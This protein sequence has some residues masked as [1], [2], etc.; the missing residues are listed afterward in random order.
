MVELRERW[1]ELG[2]RVL[3]VFGSVVLTLCLTECG[4]RVFGAAPLP[5]TAAGGFRADHPLLRLLERDKCHPF[6]RPEGAYWVEVCTNG[7]GLRDRNH[8]PGESP[9]VLGLGDSFTFGWGVEQGDTFLAHLERALRLALPGKRPGVWNAGLSYTSQVHQ[10]ALL[11]YVHQEAR[12]DLVVLAFAEDNDIDE[13]IIWNPNNGVFPEQGEISQ[14]QVDAYREELQGVIVK[15]FLFRHM[16]LVRFFRQR[17]VRASV[18]AEVSALETQLKAHGLSDAP[19]S[20]MIADEARR[21]FLQAFSFKYDDDW[22]VTEILLERIRRFLAERGTSLVL[23]R[24]PS[25]M[26]VDDRAWTNAVS[27]FCGKDVGDVQTNCGTLDRSHTAQRL[28]EYA[29]RQGVAYLDPSQDLH[30][31]V[32]RGENIYLPEDIHLSRLGHLRLGERLARD[33]LPALGAAPPS[34]P[35]PPAPNTRGTRL[36]GAYF[37]PWYRAGDWRSFT[38]YSPKGGDYIST[39]KATIHKQLQ[40]AERGEIDF[41]IIE[42]VA[43]HNRESKFNN[44]AIDTLVRTIAERRRRGHSRLKFA[45]LS[46]IFVGETEVKTNERWLELTRQHLDTIWTKYVEPFQDAYVRLDGKPLLGVFSPPVAIDDARFALFRPYWISH[47][48]WKDWS[49]KNEMVPFWDTYPQTVTDSRFVSVTPG[50]NDW[51][52]ERKP[53]VAPYLPR[54]GGHTLVEQWRRVFEVNPEV[55]LVY[56][57]N[58]YFEQTQIE[59][60]V[61]QGD[62]YL[63]LNALLARKYKDRQPLSNAE[64]ERLAAILEPPAP[65]GEEKVAWLSIADPRVQQH[66]LTKLAED[67]AS[68]ST[69]AE[70][71]ISV[72]SQKAYVIGISH[73]PS[74]ER[75]AGLS[76]SIEGGM[77]GKPVSFSTEI[78]QLAVLRDLP[79]PSSVKR[80]KLKLAKVPL[81]PD[82]RDAGQKPV[83]I[84][85]VTRYALETAE[86]LNFEVHDPKLTLEGFWDIEKPPDGS[87]AWSTARST[88]T[89]AGLSPRTRYR[90]TLSF[91]DTANFGNLELGADH[92]HLER[93]VVTPGKTVTLPQPIAASEDGKVAVS[94]RTPTWRPSDLFGAKD[95]RALGVALRLVTLD[96]I[97]GVASP[98]PHH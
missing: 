56:S 93:L 79:Q 49:R 12:P 80:L 3:L 38:D 60:T 26:S 97:E 6:G 30:A 90:V 73:A 51:R 25:Q 27:R 89:I 24:V 92:E 48:Q 2:T 54:R 75:C 53:Q 57:Y 71:E 50:Y 86:R 83:V 87:F 43:D 19:L 37:Y 28:A 67:R 29:A 21:R 63:L 62:R 76:V 1:R 59:P 42:L 77:A 17:H 66:G 20:R 84:H 13:N 10:A 94:L 44:E 88:V 85:G 41:L 69:Q 36:V 40:F 64:A 98:A 81:T 72:E 11:R 65:P 7:L 61:E 16:A 32:Q 5:E 23:L 15:D 45:I 34:A 31:A 58:E 78:T 39:D 52:L 4:L 9:R 96:R 55:V 33:V 91:R 22:K 95:Q 68:L 74:F 14:T 8:A 46:D 47:A 82:C 18:A 35:A 70:L